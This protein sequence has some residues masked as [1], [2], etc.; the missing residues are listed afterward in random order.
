MKLT[1]LMLSACVA[2]LALVACNKEETAPVD[3]NL[4][5]VQLS[6]ENIIMTK[7]ISDPIRPDA[8]GEMPPVEV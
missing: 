1:K 8:N 3:G 4:K 2:A 5:T 6:L 7:G